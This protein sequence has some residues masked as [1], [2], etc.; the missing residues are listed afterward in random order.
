DGIGCV[1][2]EESS[3]QGH[4]VSFESFA[5][6]NRHD[7]DGVAIIFDALDIRIVARGG[8]ALRDVVVKQVDYFPERDS[9]PRRIARQNLE[10]VLVV[11]QFAAGVRQQQA[12][13]QSTLVQQR[14]EQVCK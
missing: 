4:D 8:R 5:F 12:S 10:D 11:R 1:V 9:V 7:L 13:G 3:V 6:V 14:V 2:C